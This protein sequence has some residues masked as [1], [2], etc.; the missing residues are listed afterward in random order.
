MTAQNPQNKVSQQ[1]GTRRF[2]TPH[3]CHAHHGSGWDGS[4]EAATSRQAEPPLS[5][6]LPSTPEQ[7]NACQPDAAVLHCGCGKRTWPDSQIC[8][9]DLHCNLR[10]LLIACTL[11]NVPPG[12]SSSAPSDSPLTRSG[13]RLLE[14]IIPPHSR[15]EI[16][17]TLLASSGNFN[18]KTKN[19]ASHRT[20]ALVS[21]RSH[22]PAA[23]A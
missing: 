5:Q 7:T 19:K 22:W 11:V 17:T 18:F 10:G 23:A 8:T 13:E 3:E 14:L 6:G 4:C 16:F 1:L 15:M 21:R 20:Q 2:D 12:R 9:F